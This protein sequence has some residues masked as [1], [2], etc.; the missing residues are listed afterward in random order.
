MIALLLTLIMGAFALD[1]N[2]LPIRV[3]IPSPTQAS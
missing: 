2:Q 3:G 1:I